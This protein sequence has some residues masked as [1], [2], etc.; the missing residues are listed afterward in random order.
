MKCLVRILKVVIE[1]E[2]ALFDR[3]DRV[4][5]YSIFFSSEGF[6]NTRHFILLEFKSGCLIYVRIFVVQKSGPF[7]FFFVLNMN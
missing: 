1:Q 3:R 7:N 4:K 2:G 6:N 5:Q